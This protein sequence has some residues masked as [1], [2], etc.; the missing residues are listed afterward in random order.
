MRKLEQRLENRTAPTARSVPGVFSNARFERHS[1]CGDK[2]QKSQPRRFLECFAHTHHSVSTTTTAITRISI[3]GAGPKHQIK[4]DQNPRAVIK[5]RKIDA[6]G[7]IILNVVASPCHRRRFSSS[8]QTPI[9]G[10][11]FESDQ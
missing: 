1:W 2:R 9:N 8:T 11:S 3:P 4:R 10:S 5:R 7:I 6:S